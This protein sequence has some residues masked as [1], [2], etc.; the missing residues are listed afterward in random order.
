MPLHS[1]VVDF[2]SYFASVEQELEPALRGKPVAVVPV[3][4]ESTCC[5]AASY[6]AKKFKVKTGTRVS[7]ARRMCP[8]LVVLQARPSTYVEYHHRLVAAVE[9]C[10]HVEAVW[11]IDEMVCE[12]T[13]KLRE[14]EKALELAHKIKRTIADQVGVWLRSSIGIAPNPFLAKTA[15]DMQ[16]PDGL[17]VIESEE[18]PGCLHRLELRDLCGIGKNMEARLHAHGIRTVEALCAAE[19]EKLR[20]VWGG[21]E[22][23]RMHRALRGE[24]VHRPPTSRSSVGHS[25]VLPPEERNDGAALAVLNRLLQKAAMRLRKLR[26]LAGGLQ[27]YV[28]DENGSKTI[29]DLHFLETQD[30]IEF[31][32]ALRQLWDG[33]KGGERR[34]MMVGVTL[35][36]LVEEGNATAPLFGEAGKRRALNTLID[37]LNEKFGKNTVYFGGAHTARKSAPMRIAFNHV[38][39][40]VSE[41]DEEDE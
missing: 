27:L 28:K 30:T 12:L 34:P 39:D 22:G 6:E 25:H 38:P 20:K 15:S 4:A 35:F 33:R 32:G 8:G 14:R 21:I 5:I 1:L 36:R 16:K 26:C 13:G 19:Q 41:G 3:M 2:N 37:R 10:I 17:V 40:L 9:S 23:E 11:S 31:I 29:S 18:L 24:Q 7:D